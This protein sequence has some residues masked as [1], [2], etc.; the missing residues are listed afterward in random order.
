M[1]LEIKIISG[2]R[3]GT[4]LKLD[5]LDINN[6]VN[7]WIKENEALEFYLE[8]N[9]KY[10]YAE[11]ILNDHNIEPTEI[12]VDNNKIKFIWTP[13]FSGHKKHECLFANYFGIAEFT[14]KLF[15]EILDEFE[16]FNFQS[17]EILASKANADNVEKMLLYLSRLSEDELY[18]I[19]QTTKYNSGFK[20]GRNSPSSNLERLEYVFELICSVLPDILKKPITKLTPI[21][22][23]I[24]PNDN[25]IFDDES[26]GWLM[27]NLSVLHECDDINK[28]HLIYNNQMFMASSLQV[29]ELEE[30]HDIYENWIIHGFLSFMIMEISK[31]LNSYECLPSYLSINQ[32]TKP[33]GYFSFFEQLNKFKKKIL[34]NQIARCENLL[35][36]AN[37]IKFHLEKILPVSK[38][39]TQRP[40]LTPKAISHLAYRSIFIEYINWFEKS[41]PDWS[42]YENL[43][44]IRNIPMLFESYCYYRVYGVLN[45]LF[46][47]K[48]MVSSY[49]EN[50]YGHEISLYREPVYWMSKSDNVLD[51]FF[52]NSEGLA[53]NKK[54]IKKRTHKHKY[55][56]RC[57]DIVIEIKLL[58]GERKLIVL[59]AK[60]TN[61]HLAV[62]KYL[63]ECTMK[64]VHG[65]HEKKTGAV[66][67]NSMSILFPSHEGHFYSFHSSEYD[68]FSKNYVTPSLQSIGI[69]LNDKK[70]NDSLNRVIVQ[71]IKN[72]IN[73]SELDYEKMS[74]L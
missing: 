73:I 27:S 6:S 13:S 22:K 68:I 53:Y 14:I 11:L 40:I 28:S 62:R 26:L 56:H 5:E 24:T 32:K 65:I 51:S 63:P 25:N 17:I 36:L 39:I 7:Y 46:D 48:L 31:Q 10:K 9:E 43:F 44:A 60:Y 3:Y 70:H 38:I 1:L 16:L 47:S 4:I 35:K 21:Q 15:N 18:S 64:Y 30:N 19:F 12:I 50:K 69:D 52:I 29:S 54:N 58:N 41:S 34:S 2:E 45:E 8:T 71:L 61:E 72:T 23:I 74:I 57:P 55:S 49:W 67:V 20:E 59:D 33:E 42:A 66:A 37:E